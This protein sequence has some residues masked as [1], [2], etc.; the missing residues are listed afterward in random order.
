M[1]WLQ[2]PRGLEDHAPVAEAVGGDDLHAPPHAAM[3][4]GGQRAA[5]P[6]R[7]RLPPRRLA[8]QDERRAVHLAALGKGGEVAQRAGEEPALRQRGVL[9]HGH[10]RGRGEARLHQPRG[11]AGGDRAA[12]V[13][14]DGGAGERQPGPVGEHVALRVVAGGED[15]AR[16]R[17]AQA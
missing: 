8:D 15:E 1:S 5:R 7:A 4:A 9:D 10:R 16:R 17:A 3:I 6:K 14:G 11:D 13:D 12:H 2:P